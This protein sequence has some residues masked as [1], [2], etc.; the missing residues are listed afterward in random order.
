MRLEEKGKMKIAFK[1]VIIFLIILNLYFCGCQEEKKVF[2]DNDKVDITDY[3]VTT[4]WYIP[5]YG[6]F[7]N[8]SKPGFYKHFPETAYN[9]RYIVKGTAK[10]IAGRNIENVIILISFYDSQLNKITSEN[11]SNFNL[12]YAQSKEF[13]VFLCVTNQNYKNIEK[14]KFY[15]S[16]D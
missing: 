14:I 5:G 2:G 13:T 3:S 6:A 4:Q 10:N 9:P 11:S 1:S 15:I 8:Y 16:A 7:Q 12:G